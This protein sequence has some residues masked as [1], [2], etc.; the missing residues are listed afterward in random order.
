MIAVCC[1]KE[2]LY[3]TFKFSSITFCRQKDT[4]TQHQ[5]FIWGNRAVSY[6]AVLGC[7]LCSNQSF[8]LR[9]VR[10]LY[11]YTKSYPVW[12]MY[13]GHLN[14]MVKLPFCPPQEC[15]H[16]ILAA[17][18]IST[19]IV[20]KDILSL[21]DKARKLVCDWLQ[22][23][24]RSNLSETLV[25]NAVPCHEEQLREA[26]IIGGALMRTDCRDPRWHLLYVDVLLAKGEM[27][28]LPK[29]AA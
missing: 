11:F 19:D 20:T 7:C 1:P 21:K 23:Y 29:G 5:N 16:D 27:E 10:Q 17:L 22:Q 13:T 15:T 14:V 9:L 2:I 12:V 6:V 8:R 4:Y 3:F 24:C 25:A 18:Q 26:F 28:T